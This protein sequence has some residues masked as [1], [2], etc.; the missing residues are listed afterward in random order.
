MCNLVPCIEIVVDAVTNIGSGECNVCSAELPLQCKSI[1]MLSSNIWNIVCV[2]V[3][4]SSMIP[5]VQ[6]YVKFVFSF[7]RC[8]GRVLCIVWFQRSI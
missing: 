2:L 3:Q 6:M 4:W 8:N 1:N 7:F 5:F